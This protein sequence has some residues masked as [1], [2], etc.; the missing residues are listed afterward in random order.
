MSRV[1]LRVLEESLICQIIEC[2]AIVITKKTQVNSKL[3]LL[4]AGENDKSEFFYHTWNCLEVT[5][6]S[7]ELSIFALYSKTITW[8]FTFTNGTMLG[9]ENSEL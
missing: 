3:L 1:K 4:C 5:I 9:S 8:N 7:S 2:L 6:M